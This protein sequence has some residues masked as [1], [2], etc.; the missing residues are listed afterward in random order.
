M[1]TR[2]R[3]FTLI[4][5]LVVISIVS[6][7]IAILLP[8]L[9]KARAAASQIQC[10]ANIRSGA[11]AVLLYVDEHRDEFPHSGNDWYKSTYAGAYLSADV[12][13]LRCDGALKAPNQAFSFGAAEPTWCPNRDLI[14]WP[15]TDE[16]PA[17]YAQ[18]LRTVKK[19]GQTFLLGDGNFRGVFRNTSLRVTDGR[20]LWYSHGNAANIVYLDTHVTLVR[21]DANGPESDI[22]NAPST[23]RA[24]SNATLWE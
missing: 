12:S 24:G 11:L 14:R 19:P 21:A 5:L 10:A 8:A 18:N 6:L 16:S 13:R 15:G 20:L 17:T 1:P 22:G 2:Q 3:A 7:L 4:E 9:A 23:W